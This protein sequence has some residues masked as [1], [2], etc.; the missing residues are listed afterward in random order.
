MNIETFYPRHPVL[1]NHIEYY[2]FLKT[3]SVDFKTAYYVF[4]N[5][6][7]AFNIHKNACCEIEDNA[8]QVYGVREKKYLMIAQGKHE[9]PLQAILKGKLDKVTI[10]FKPLGLNHFIDK[11]LAVVTPL[12]SQLFHDWDQHAATQ[13]F[14][15]AFFS[16]GDNEARVDLLEDYLLRFYRPLH[17]EDILIKAMDSLM[18]FDTEIPIHQIAEELSL[19]IRSFN[20]L[21]YNNAGISPVSF[22]K[23]ARFRHSMKNR[24]FSER[25]KNLTE[26]GYESNFYDQAY[27]VKMYKKITGS[28]P[29]K[30]FKSID[31][32]ADNQ[33]IFQFL[34]KP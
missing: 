14:L 1:K 17:Q 31:K 21:F 24:L 10:I 34:N 13:P 33:L 25:F 28:N 32:L 11:P 29:A 3:H 2:Y 7:Q 23:I 22:R 4:P 5:T 8:V 9:A 20:R 15:H 18:N 27:F 6:L 26:I 30:F 12:H 16:A 19:G